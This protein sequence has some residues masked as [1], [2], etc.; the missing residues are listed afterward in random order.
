MINQKMRNQGLAGLVLMCSVAACDSGTG[1]TQIST[2]SVT[3]IS[4]PETLRTAFALDPSELQ[5]QVT[6]NDQATVLQPDADSIWRGVVDVPMNQSLRVAV[7]WGT[8]YGTS[9]YVKLAEQQ[10]FVFVGADEASV[11]F[12]DTYDTAFDH[13]RD[14]LNN[15]SEIQQ[16]RSPVDR[17]DVTINTDG[18]FATGGISFPS[19]GQC[20]QQIPIAV[21]TTIGADS[22]HEGWWCAT[23]E[24]E[25]LDA[26]GNPQQIENL[27]IVVSVEDLQLYTDNSTADNLSHHDD[28]IEIFIDGDGNRSGS[29]DGINDFQF[30][31]TQRGPY[32]PANMSGSIEYRT[33]GYTLTAVIPLQEV[34]IQNGFPFGLNVSVN[35]DDDGGNR[36]TKYDW[37]ADEEEDISWFNTRGF[38]TSQVP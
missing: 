22:D 17:L 4:L 18:T 11:L 2:G 6:V 29:Y 12:D 9:G 21:R 8:D 34:G 14:T 13:D 15:L 24:Q 19:S 38:G 36:D 37:I 31:F 32:S 3:E 16:S 1:T 20:G 26:D 35:D 5:L 25:L 27:K 23:V 7:E 28:S 10:R 30:R 33:G